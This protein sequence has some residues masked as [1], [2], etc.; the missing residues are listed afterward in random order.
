MFPHPQYAEDDGLLAFGGDLSP[1]RI[2]FAYSLGIFPWFNE[3]PILW[4]SPNPRFVLFP[5]KLRVSDSMKKAIKKNYFQISFDTD[6]KGVIKGCRENRADEAGTWISNDIIIAYTKLF[7]LGI[8]HSVEVRENGRLVGGLY[9]LLIGT[10]FYGESMFHR[11]TNASKAGFIE[12]V[13]K[14][15]NAGCK[16]IDCQVYTKHLES[17]GAENLDRESFMQILSEENTN[18][19]KPLFEKQFSL[20]N[21]PDKLAEKE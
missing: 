15:K 5:E 7:E 20:K 16:L 13:Q 9:G 11:T 3:P 12:L 14:L 10:V 8:A 17:L 4:W 2:V 21:S 1:E 18:T 19:L 6:F